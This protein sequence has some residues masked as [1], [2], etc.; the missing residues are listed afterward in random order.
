MTMAKKPSKAAY[1]KAWAWAK[2]NVKGKKA[3]ARAAMKRAWK[4][5]KHGHGK[6]KSRGGRKHGGGKSKSRGGRK[7]GHVAVKGMSMAQK[8]KSRALV[9]R[10]VARG[11]TQAEAES[12]IRKLT[13]QSSKQVKAAT[14]KAAAKAARDSV[15]A[16]AFAG[17]GMAGRA[18]AVIPNA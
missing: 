3:Q 14:E 6:S 4:S 11:Y 16:N 12:R 7:H 5:A 18:A 15:L 17:F 2:K 1:K 8:L 9:A 10:L 13:A